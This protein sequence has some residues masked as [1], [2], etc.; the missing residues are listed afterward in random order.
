MDKKMVNTK[1]TLNHIALIKSQASRNKRT[2]HDELEL[3]FD[4]YFKNKS[5]E[6]EF[7]NISKGETQ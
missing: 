7:N 4:E 3:I 6:T 5:N 2:F 1:Y